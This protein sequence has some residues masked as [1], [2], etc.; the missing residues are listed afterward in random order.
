MN[1]KKYERNCFDLQFYRE[2]PSI[3]LRHERDEVED[4]CYDREILDKC[5]SVL[6][7]ERSLLFIVSDR[8]S[9]LN[10]CS[11]ELDTVTRKG[12]F[13]E[14]RLRALDPNWF[15]PYHGDIPA[16]FR[17]RRDAWNELGAHRLS[18]VLKF[19][20]GLIQGPLRSDTRAP[21]YE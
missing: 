11:I 18:T 12:R 8:E 3:P 5:Y 15:P 20:R 10:Q 16:V 17:P 14:G 2:K 21:D 6:D 13:L 7:L 1:E 19:Q 4:E 9:R